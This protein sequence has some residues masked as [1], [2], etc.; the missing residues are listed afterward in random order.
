ML[1]A[2]GDIIGGAVKPITDIINKRVEDRDLRNQLIADFQSKEF[3][4]QISLLLGQMKLN[5]QEAKHKSVFVAGWRPAV[6]WVCAAGLAINFVVIPVASPWVDVQP[7]DMTTMMPV[8]LGMLGLGGL[9]T[10]EKTK[11]VSREG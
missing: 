7:T 9:R 5:T 6:G 11:G 2:I 10:F 3:Q 1:G 4:G 8:L